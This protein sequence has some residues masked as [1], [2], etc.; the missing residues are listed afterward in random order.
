MIDLSQLKP[1]SGSRKKK[2]RVGR[3]NNSSAAG[4]Y[5]GRGIKGQR[6]RSG[7]K[8]GLKLKGMMN[9][10]KAIPKKKGF[11]PRPSSVNIVN[12][13][14]LGKKFKEGDIVNLEGLIK[15]GFLKKNDKKVKILGKGQLKKKLT[16]KAHYFSKQAQKMIEK[17]G[18]KTIII[19]T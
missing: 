5:A 3:G 1:K 16:V 6:A 10:L 7:G 9:I 15:A 14:D 12:I 2:K 11:K 18:G 17:A 4:T 19:K 8:K 13:G